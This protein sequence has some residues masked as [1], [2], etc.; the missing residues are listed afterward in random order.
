[1]ILRN[2]RVNSPNSL[3][4]VRKATVVM[5]NS[6]FLNNASE[7]LMRRER[8]YCLGLMPTWLLNSR[9][10]WNLLRE[11]AWAMASRFNGAEMF[12]SMNLTALRIFAGSGP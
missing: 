4:P 5:V 6:G 1:M 2:W 12:V 9:L 11:A 8:V 10:K 3:K 7:R